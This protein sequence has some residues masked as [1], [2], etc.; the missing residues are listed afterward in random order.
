M[1]QLSP[2]MIITLLSVG[3]SLTITII[4]RVLTKPE[5][6]R[7]MKDD[8]KFYKDKMNQAKK[9]GDN[10]KMNE[11]AS[12]MLKASQTQFRMSMKPMIVT[13]MLF[14][15]LLGWLNGNFGGVTASFAGDTEGRFVYQEENH[16]M[17]YDNRTDGFTV[18]VDFNDDG[19]FSDGE[20]F[21]NGEIFEHKG[22]LWRPMNT[23]EGFLIFQKENPESVHFDMF[24]AEM[25]FEL[26]F[27]GS[28]LT[29]FWWYIFISLPATFILRKLMGVE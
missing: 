24:I 7:K 5:E 21:E 14:F 9:E 18:G 15:M 26:P 2:F 1:I 11:Y 10:A 16:T 25:P 12:E 6:V 13:M 23:M 3:L 29:W 27:I 28:Y 20:T 22:A 8:M 17:T 4:Y 19:A